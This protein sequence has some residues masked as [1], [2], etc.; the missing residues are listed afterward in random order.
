MKHIKCAEV[1]NPEIIKLALKESANGTS[2]LRQETFSP[3]NIPIG[4]NQNVV[5]LL[6]LQPFAVHKSYETPLFFLTKK[7]RTL[8]TV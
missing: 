7:T 1:V 4:H 5:P 3:Q 2:H 8:I 6:Y